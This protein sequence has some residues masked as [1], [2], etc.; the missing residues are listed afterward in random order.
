MML[1]LTKENLDRT[2]AEVEFLAEFVFKETL[3]RF[4]DV[5]RKITEERE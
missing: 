5:L 3:V 1:F 2:T 4:A